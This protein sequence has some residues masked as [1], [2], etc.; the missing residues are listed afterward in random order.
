[1]SGIDT[2]QGFNDNPDKKDG[3]LQ[4][5]NKGDLLSFLGGNVETLFRKGSIQSN[6]GG[7]LFIGDFH[8]QFGRVATADTTI[9]VTYPKAFANNNVFAFIQEADNDTGH[10][11]QLDGNNLPNATRLVIIN[12]SGPVATAFYYWLVI[13]VR[14]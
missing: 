10:Q 1:M 4:L 13:G 5:T 7:E 11:A 6:A 2:E 14:A 12:N 8:I 9:T 3:D